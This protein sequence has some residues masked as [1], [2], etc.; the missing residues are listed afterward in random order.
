MEFDRASIM[1]AEQAFGISLDTL[2]QGGIPKVSDLINLFHASLLKHHPH[3]KRP[4]VEHLFE[5][6]SDKTGLYSDLV[7]MYGEVIT[8]LFVKEP[9]KNALKR[10]AF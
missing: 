6:Q 9:A 8:P 2:S 3:I 1:A 7:E 5:L 4:V 10:E